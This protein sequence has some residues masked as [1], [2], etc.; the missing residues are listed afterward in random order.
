M[1]ELLEALLHDRFA[2]PPLTWRGARQADGVR[3]AIAVCRFGHQA[4]LSKHTIAAD[5]AVTPSVVCP[6]AN[7]SWHEV[8]KLI[9]WEP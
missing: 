7:C 9:G 6:T 5:G 8:V 2:L 3:T 1:V 4:S